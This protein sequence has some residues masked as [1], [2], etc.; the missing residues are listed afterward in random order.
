M[1]D[2]QADGESIGQS[3]VS[4]V[5]P[6]LVDPQLVDPQQVDPQ[7][8][9]PST[10]IPGPASIN[11][12]LHGRSIDR[13]TDGIGESSHHSKIGERDA[14]RQRDGCDQSDGGVH[15]PS[16]R[17]EQEQPGEEKP[18]GKVESAPCFL[19]F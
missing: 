11:I 15:R 16:Q 9:D 2:L 18:G 1:C 6:Q 13:L 10:G 5:D 19:A 3:G 4:Q 12:V 14:D 7:Q 17:N 8:V